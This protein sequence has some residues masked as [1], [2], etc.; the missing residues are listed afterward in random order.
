[1]ER[2]LLVTW[3]DLL[4]NMGFSQIKREFEGFM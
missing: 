1:M 4:H 3:S 2:W